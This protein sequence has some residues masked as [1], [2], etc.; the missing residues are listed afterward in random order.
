[1]ARHA[2]PLAS[3]LLVLLGVYGCGRGTPLRYP[4]VDVDAGVDGG[5][6]DGGVPCIPGVVTL[7]RARATV[8]FVLDRSGSMNDPFGD[9]SKWGALGRGLNQ[10]LPGVDQT[11]A[12]GAYL[13]PSTTSLDT[14]AVRS[15]AELSPALGNVD[16]LVN[17]FRTYSPRGGTPTADA[18]PQAAAVL[19]RIRAARSARA[20]VLATDGAPGC[21]RTLDANTC[22]CTL[23]SS[24]LQPSPCIGN[25]GNCLDDVRTIAALDA[26]TASGLPT[27]VIGI[28]NASDAVFID[29]LNRMAVAGGKPRATSP[30]FYPANSPSQLTQALTTIRDQV[31]SC[32]FLTTSVPDAQGD[33]RVILNGREVPEDPTGQEGWSWADRSNGELVFAGVACVEAS[34]LA[35][36]T[37]NVGCSGP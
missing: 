3:L 19:N 37:A 4:L 26:I 22:V 18:L 24:P 5:L 23:P 25:P 35:V 36:V 29:V 13:F 32:T 1:M 6:E 21:N 11:M 15:T 14:C 34:T 31:G 28:Q 10:S 33:I 9:T 8:L 2:L 27:W 30:R 20:L 12:V 7:T 16:N 17:L